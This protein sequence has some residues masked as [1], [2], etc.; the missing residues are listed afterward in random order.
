[1]SVL[2]DGAR[3]RYRLTLATFV[4]VVVHELAHLLA[5]RLYGLPVEEVVLFDPSIPGGYVRHG[6]RGSFTPVFVVGVAP[7]L[8]NTAVGV[9]IVAA[10][11]AAWPP[12]VGADPA[13]VATLLAYP[14]GAWV[15]VSALYQ[16]FPSRQDAAALWDHLRWLVG[17]RLRYL[18]VVPFV[19]PF[20]AFLYAVD[21]GR[22]VWA[23]AL[24]AVCVVGLTV[25][26]AENPEAV[27][28]IVADRFGEVRAWVEAALRGAAAV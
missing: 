20:V 26:A 24:Y 2:R 25:W 27:A 19:A 5:C 1:M 11:A 18:L 9:G 16:A 8:L 4:G 6:A 17:A 3:L 7:F 13:A 15:A 23:D 28:G 22:R 10:L 21:L 12:A 14:L